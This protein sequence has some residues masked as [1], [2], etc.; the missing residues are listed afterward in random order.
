MFEFLKNLKVKE[1]ISA[2][3][4]KV[5]RSPEGLSLRV[6][7]SGK[8][9]PSV[10][11]IDKFKLEYG[12]SGECG[13]DFFSSRDWPAYPKEAPGVVFITFVPRGEPK[14]DLF[15]SRRSEDTSVLTQG[16]VADGLY[17]MV[18]ETYGKKQGFS[19]EELKS[20]PYIDI[21]V[22]ENFALNTENGIYLLPKKIMRG[23]RKGEAQYLRRENIT[24]Y[25]LSL[26]V[27]TKA[28]PAAAIEQTDLLAEIQ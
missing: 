22:M 7:P 12:V 27:E 9:Y 19:E 21:Y 18:L 14:I 25:P 5:T 3:A 17:E 16:P 13:I 10:A 24:L 28:E 2:P 1:S 26:T 4:P 11:L 6:F 23:E 8:V 20:K 15:A